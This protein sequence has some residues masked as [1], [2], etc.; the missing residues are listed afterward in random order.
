MLNHE[1]KNGIEIL[2]FDNVN[3]LNNVGFFT[4]TKILSKRDYEKKEN[5][6]AMK[7]MILYFTYK[8]D[9]ERAAKIQKDIKDIYGDDK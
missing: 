7:E 3:K 8:G 6:G 9:I 2:T 4:T 1:S 5:V